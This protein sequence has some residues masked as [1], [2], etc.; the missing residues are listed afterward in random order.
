MG[1]HEADVPAEQPAPQ[2]QARLPAPDV[3]E[4]RSQD[5]EAASRP[6]AQEP[7]RLERGHLP[8][9][10]RMRW[11]TLKSRRQ[12][13][14]V[15]SQGRKRVAMALVVFHLENAPDRQVAFVASRK[16]GGAVQ[17]NRAKRLMR[18]AFREVGASQTMPS[19]W[20]VLVARRDILELKSYQV[21]EELRTLLRGP[22]VDGVPEVPP[23]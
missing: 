1:F 7:Q 16:V 17:R 23:T 11:P 20:L 5:P 18:E 21:A 4:G 14:L 10:L 3:D 6:W 9:L 13:N 12:F 15:Y 2:T 22:R 19:G 8:A